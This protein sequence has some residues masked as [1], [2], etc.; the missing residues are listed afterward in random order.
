[1][2]TL[3]SKL[4]SDPSIKWPTWNQQRGPFIGL[5]KM[6]QEAWIEPLAVWSPLGSAPRNEWTT[7]NQRRGRVE[8]SVRSQRKYPTWL[9][10]TPSLPQTNCHTPPAEGFLSHPRNLNRSLCWW[11]GKGAFI[12][13]AGRYDRNPFDEEEDVNP[14]AVLIDF[15]PSFVT[16]L[17]PPSF[18]RRSNVTRLASGSCDK[19]K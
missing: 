19:H 8:T 5:S 3:H 15:F 9:T 14:F 11:E 17:C 18:C 4:L 16:L 6:I 2:I 7:H 10:I 12:V 1:M 13:M